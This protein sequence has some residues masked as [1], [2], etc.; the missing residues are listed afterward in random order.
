ME[1]EGEFSRFLEIFFRLKY[2]K[3]DFPARGATAAAD[4]NLG[5]F[6]HVS[7]R[8]V[9][10]FSAR[11]NIVCAAHAT[12]VYYKLNL[13]MKVQRLSPAEITRTITM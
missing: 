5:C 6:L 13:Y 4:K 2:A 9:F 3:L 8:R 10:F 12:M 1:V 11:Y 7:A